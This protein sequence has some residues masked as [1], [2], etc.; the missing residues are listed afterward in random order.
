MTMLSRSVAAGVLTLAGLAFAGSARAEDT[1]LLNLPGPADQATTFDLK[2]TDADLDPY[3]IDVARGGRGGGRAGFRGG[4]RGGFRA[5]HFRGG[6]RGVGWRGWGWRGRGWGVGWRGWGVGWRGR[7]WGVGLGWPGY[8]YY[9]RY[10]Y[11]AY[12]P[13]VYYP[14]PVAYGYSPCVVTTA[15]PATTL[16]VVPSPG[17]EVIPSQ[18]GQGPGTFPYDGGPKSPVPM[19]KIEETKHNTPHAPQLID[20]VL[21]S[22]P[23]KSGKWNFPAYG[24]TPKRSGGLKSS[25]ISTKT[26]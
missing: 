11:G 13:Q 12:Y 15:V 2:A 4:F 5:G 19:P 1:V 25:V 17:R 7:G 10:W 20:D 3:I 22:V 6:F 24:E 9:P 26:R 23:G 14:Y 16:R 18:Q 21:V 8:R